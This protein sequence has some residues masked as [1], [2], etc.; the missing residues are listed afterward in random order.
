MVDNSSQVVTDSKKEMVKK[1]NK[2]S[3]K[4]KEQ[5]AKF[6][7]PIGSFLSSYPKS[8]LFLSPHSVPALVSA[9]V[10]APMPTLLPRFESPIVLSFGRMP[11]TAASVTFSLS[12]HT[13][14]SC[15]GILAFLSPLIVLGPL[16]LLRPSSLGIYKQSFSDEPWPCM[17]TSP[18]KPLCPFLT[19]SKYNLDN[20]N[21]LHNCDNKNG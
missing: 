11:A 19:L 6:R 13:S 2:P 5:L 21:G 20:N 1:K 18:T 12:R 9:L 7:A 4:R 16:F 15:C 10:P 8:S 14:V 3:A 17:L